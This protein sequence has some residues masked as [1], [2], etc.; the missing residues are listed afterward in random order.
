LALLKKAG[1]AIAV[2]NAVKEV[3]DAAHYVTQARG[4]NG[5]VREIAEMILKAQDKW[6]QVVESFA[7]DL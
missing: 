2:S 7:A 3:K 4:G 5:A 6:A 1:A